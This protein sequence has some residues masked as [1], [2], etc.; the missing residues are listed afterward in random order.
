MVFPCFRRILE[1]YQRVNDLRQR[2]E[3]LLACALQI[4]KQSDCNPK[5]GPFMVISEW[6]NP[7]EW[8]FQPENWDLTPIDLI[9]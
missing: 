2:P 3:K 7:Y 8:R 5:Q 4:A 6:M 9:G 1:E